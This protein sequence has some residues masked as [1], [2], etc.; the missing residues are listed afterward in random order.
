MER[1]VLFF[2]EEECPIISLI[3]AQWRQATTL[4]FSQQNPFTIRP[5]SEKQYQL[6]SEYI[7]I[8]MYY[9]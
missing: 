1:P 4:L 8:R 6:S 9:S 3:L 7:G 2:I 5:F